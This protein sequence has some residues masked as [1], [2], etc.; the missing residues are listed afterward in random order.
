[1]TDEDAL[2]PKNRGLGRGLNALFEDEEGEYPQVDPEGH[3]PGVQR[4]MLGIE[5]IEAHPDQPRQI[6]D[7]QALADLTASIKEHGVLQPILVRASKHTPDQ[8]EIIAGER[9][10]RASQRAQLHEIPVV[11]REM[12]DAQA[13]QIALIEN[14]QRHDLNPIEEAKGYQSLIDDFGHKPEEVGETIGK[15]RSHVANMVRLLGL[16]NSVQVMV[17]QGDISAG[18]ARALLKAPN[19]TL[20]A[21]EVISKGLSVRQTEKLAADSEGRDIKTRSSGAK[22]KSFGPAKD[23]DTLALEKE[24]SNLLGMSV[25]LSM[26]TD[27]EGTLS[28]EFKDLDQ[29]DDLLQRLSQTPARV[30]FG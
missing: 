27:K 13:L 16:P 18:H 29:L 24:I 28:I 6:F 9:R 30:E 2:N 7:E 25:T 20:L 23:A 15:S 17:M 1:M 14:L 3:T 12:D 22:S 21:Q 26:K 10:W 8:Y 19:P 11:V 5:Q 4:K